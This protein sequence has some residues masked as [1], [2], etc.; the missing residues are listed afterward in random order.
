MK[1]LDTKELDFIFGGKADFSNVQ[2]GFSTSGN[3]K[4]VK[5]KSFL[6]KIDPFLPGMFR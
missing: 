1:V 5:E 4:E 6:E 3:V 2:T